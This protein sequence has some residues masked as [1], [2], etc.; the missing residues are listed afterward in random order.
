MK[1]PAGSN[2]HGASQQARSRTVNGGNLPPITN[3]R[4]PKGS[5]NIRRSI[6][7]GST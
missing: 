4:M 5:F 6:V 3:R 2:R 1:R 7:G